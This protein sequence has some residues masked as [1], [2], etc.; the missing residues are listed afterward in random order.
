[1]KM[2]KRLYKIDS[3]GSI[4]KN[5]KIRRREGYSGEKKIKEQRPKE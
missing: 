2:R 4:R 1:M 3:R 5:Y